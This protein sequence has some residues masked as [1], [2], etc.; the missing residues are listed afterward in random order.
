[1]TL[2]EMAALLEMSQ[3]TLRQQIKKGVLTAEKV[4]TGTH[5]IWMV[6]EEEV[7]RYRREHHGKRGYASPRYQRKP[8]G[9][10]D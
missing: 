2:A 9:G 3:P 6:T 4:G 7:E 10:V 1:M 5:S 8:K